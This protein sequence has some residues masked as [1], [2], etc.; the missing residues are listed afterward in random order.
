MRLRP[1]LPRRSSVRGLAVPVA[2]A[3]GA[4]AVSY[5]LR[6]RRRVAWPTPDDGLQ[7]SQ[8]RE[9]TRELLAQPRV[10]RDDL[11][12]GFAPSFA[13]SVEPLLHGRRYFPRILEDIA[14]ATDHVHLLIYGYKEGEIGRTFLDAL[15]GQGARRRRGPNGGRCHR[16]RDRRRQQRAV[17]GSSCGRRPDRRERGTAGHPDRS[18]SAAGGR[19]RHIGDLLHFDHRKMIVVDGRIGYV[20]GSG[21]EDHYNDETFYDVMCRVTGPIVA[22]LALT[23]LV[24]WRHHNGPVPDGDLVALL[25]GGRHGRRERPTKRSGPPCSGTSPGP[26]TIRSAT[27]SSS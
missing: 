18:S 13:T 25:S 3:T 9:R 16:Q 12:I 22:Q 8:A 7:A 10:G 17:P 21:I 20:G 11:A 23:F 2:A 26:A 5:R 27:R 6:S 24:T 19:P 14:A 4:A 1:N 15:R